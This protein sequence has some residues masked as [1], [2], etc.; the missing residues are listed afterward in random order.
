MH[1]RITEVLNYL[2]DQ[3]AGLLAAVAEV[4]PG[5][6]S[7][8]PAPDRWSA[9]QVV[10]HLGLV[11]GSI[12]AMLRHRLVEAR[13]AG[14]DVDPD[15]SPIL[16]TLDVARLLDRERALVAGERT[17]PPET[18][19]VD[20]ALAILT[21]TRESLRREIIR[22]DGLALGTIAAPHPFLGSLNLYQWLIFLGAHEARHAAQIREVAA[23]FA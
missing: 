10:S 16:P 2:D 4:P 3:R 17:R 14:L 18:P 19:L 6:A 21:R 12:A 22:A 7:R 8:R 5:L 15:S 11:E 13:A 9:A 1:A 20:D 23:A